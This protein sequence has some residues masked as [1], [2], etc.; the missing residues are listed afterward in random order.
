MQSKEKNRKP[1][2]SKEE[3]L[4]EV[5]HRVVNI[6][7]DSWKHVMI[8]KRKTTRKT[9]DATEKIRLGSLFSALI[10]VFFAIIAVINL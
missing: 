6:D 7:K 5:F 8:L 1:N 2:D 4:D 10:K 3:T 9:I